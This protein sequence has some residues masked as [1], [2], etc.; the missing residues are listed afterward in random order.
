MTGGKLYMEVL[1]HS[2]LAGGVVMASAARLIDMPGI[3]VL[4]GAVV[5]FISAYQFIKN[6]KNRELSKFS[7]P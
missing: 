5:G 3:P 2:T 7:A 6:F 1:L 4:C